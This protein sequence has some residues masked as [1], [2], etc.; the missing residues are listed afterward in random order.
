M[1]LIIGVVVGIW[2]CTRRR[3]RVKEREEKEEFIVDNT[4][5]AMQPME[6]METAVHP[7]TPFRREYKLGY[8]AAPQTPTL[9]PLLPRVN[10]PQ[11]PIVYA[12]SPLSPQR[13]QPHVPFAVPGRYPP[14]SP[15]AP[16]SE[17]ASDYAVDAGP[18][19]EQ[20]P[21]RYDPRWSRD[22]GKP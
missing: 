16:P 19:R 10:A 5:D 3:H 12:H 11:P 1:A 20:H 2:L 7:I 13:Q 15:H 18:V 22:Q 14:A 6:A 9:A 17:Y 8:D 4:A 21:P